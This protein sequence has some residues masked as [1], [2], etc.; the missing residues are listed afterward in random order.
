MTEASSR[1]HCSTKIFLTM[2]GLNSGLSWTLASDRNSR[3]AVG[4]G[5]G[6]ARSG[7]AEEL[8]RLG[9]GS[10]VVIPLAESTGELPP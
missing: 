7:T 10:G 5:E 2:L 6:R 3:S 4:R 1:L 8:Q 9:R